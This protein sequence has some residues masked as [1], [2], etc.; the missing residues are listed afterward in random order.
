MYVTFYSSYPI[1]VRTPML[2]SSYG[3]SKNL[4]RDSTRVVSR[5]SHYATMDGCESFCIKQT[6]DRRVV[7]ERH[8]AD[9]EFGIY[10]DLKTRKLFFTEFHR[11]SR[12]DVR[13][14]SPE[15]LSFVYSY[16]NKFIT[17]SFCIPSA[18]N[19]PARARKYPPIDSRYC[20]CKCHCN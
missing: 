17:R 4:S 12:L 19:V 6:A 1:G 16:E 11:S 20:V 10:R 3:L 2:I 5:T 7:I 9:F 13:D 14:I 8:L 15:R 18:Y